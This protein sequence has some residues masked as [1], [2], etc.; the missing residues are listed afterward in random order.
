MSYFFGVRPETSYDT[1][2]ITSESPGIFYPIN[3]SWHSS[4]WQTVSFQIVLTLYLFK[5][6]SLL[7]S[8]SILSAL[9]NQHSFSLSLSLSSF[10]HSVILDVHL[11]LII[12][13]LFSTRVHQSFDCRYSHSL[14]VSFYFC[15]YLSSFAPTPTPPTAPTPTATAASPASAPRKARARSKKSSRA[16]PNKIAAC[17]QFSGI[18]A[19]NKCELDG[20]KWP[21]KK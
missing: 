7:Q 19:R 6:S 12:R 13:H 3:L 17:G 14:M 2:Q 1:F 9:A 8:F 4:Y 5:I 21:R 16:L 18:T 20:E 15:R 10:E 11:T